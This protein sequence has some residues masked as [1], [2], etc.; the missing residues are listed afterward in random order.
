MSIMSRHRWDNGTMG[1]RD[2]GTTGRED[3]KGIE[4]LPMPTDT[5]VGAVK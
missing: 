4:G 2:S 1:Q 3:E 5:R